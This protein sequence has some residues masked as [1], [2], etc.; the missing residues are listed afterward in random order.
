MKFNASDYKPNE[1]IKFIREGLNLTQKEMANAANLHKSSI[2]KYEYGI[3]NYSFE[4]LL[5]IA[6]KYD[7]EIII[8][9]KKKNKHE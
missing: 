6:E 2:E 4:T 1:L 3:M 8:Q 7:L 9:S 5:T